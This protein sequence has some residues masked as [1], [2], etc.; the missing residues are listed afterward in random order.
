MELNYKD[1]K[2]PFNRIIKEIH[3]FKY[4]ISNY[5]ISYDNFKMDGNFKNEDSVA[6]IKL[7]LIMNNNRII[8]VYIE[9]NRLYPFRSPILYINNYKYF[10]LLV[11]DSIQLEKI[12]Y[13]YE[14]MCCRSLLCNWNPIFNIISIMKE[15]K[16]NYEIIIKIVNF[17]YCK[18]IVDKYLNNIDGLYKNINEYL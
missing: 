12:K 9:F 7:N 13:P 17:I 2:L 8:N 1:Y 5:F 3:N 11:I 4:L 18:K 15:V 14:C 10:D 6:S 16:Q